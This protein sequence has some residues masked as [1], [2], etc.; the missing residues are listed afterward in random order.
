MEMIEADRE[1]P[2]LTIDEVAKLLRLSRVT[3][4]RRVR[5]GEIPAVRT[6]RKGSKI[7]IDRRE[8]ERWLY[9]NPGD[10]A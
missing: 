7:R 6:G 5:S 3:I 9:S 1:S 4:E 8:L 10:A 2:L